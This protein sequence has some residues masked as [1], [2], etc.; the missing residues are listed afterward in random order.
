MRSRLYLYQL[1]LSILSAALLASCTLSMEEWAIPEEQRGQGEIYTEENEYGRI[2]Y[3]FADSVLYVT[4]NIQEQY[5]VRVEADSILYFSDQM[6]EEWRPYV[7]Q[8]MAAGISHLLPYGLNSRVISVVNYGGFI[9][10]V[11]T[12]VNLETVYKHLKYSFDGYASAPDIDPDQIDSIDLEDYG[13]QM[14]IDPETGDTTITDWND[15]DISKGIRPAYARRRSLRHTRADDIPEEKIGKDNIKSNTLIELSLDTRASD[16]GK[17]KE[18]NGYMSAIK[19]VFV[20][21]LVAEVTKASK[22]SKNG[23]VYAAFRIK[24]THFSK[25]HALKDTDAGVEEEWTDTWSEWDF[26]VETG[27]DYKREGGKMDPAVDDRLGVPM[28]G[29]SDMVKSISARNAASKPMNPVAMQKKRFSYVKVRIPISAVPVAFAIIVEG[30]ITPTFELNGCISVSSKYTSDVVRTGSRVVKGQAPEKF[31]DKVVKEGSFT[32]PSV[33]INGS[34]KVGLK[35]RIA[36]GFEVG[37]T[38]GVTIGANIEGY[39]EGNA[40]FKIAVK[41]GTSNMNGEPKQYVTW[42]DFSGTPFK[43]YVDVYG[44][45]TVFV[46]PLGIPVWEKQVVKFLTKRLIN[47]IPEST[48]GIRFKGGDSSFGAELGKEYEGSEYESIGTIYGWYVP[49]NSL[50]PF[51]ALMGSSKFYPAMKLYVGDIKDDKWMWMKRAHNEKIETFLPSSQWRLI[52]NHETYYFREYTYWQKLDNLAGKKAGYIYLVPTFV[53]FSSD[54]ILHTD[55]NFDD[56]LVKDAIDEVIEIKE[57]AVMIDVAKPLIETVSAKHLES[58]DMDGTISHGTYISKDKGG[59]QNASQGSQA[60]VRQYFFYAT[61]KVQGGSY[62]KGWG[63][64]VYV[65][66]PNKK[67]LMKKI[68]PVNKLRS[69]RYTFLFSFF[70]DWAPQ[71]MAN[72]EGDNTSKLYFCV[73]PY[74]E[75]ELEGEVMTYNATDRKSTK[76]YPIEYFLE[77]N[78]NYWD[79][80]KKNKGIFG[81]SDNIILTP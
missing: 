57:S 12:R 33:L 29:F 13:F 6:P 64:T 26:A 28:F 59:V 1:V 56:Q 46:A 35:G 31:E 74:W 14:Q 22:N 8:K 66:S 20:E 78:S 60:A 75:M 76:S 3:E 53:S 52:E 27:Y 10:A 40:S 25:F 19:K 16:I 23:E 34:Y 37:G 32:A 55:C 45:V 18:T 44:D 81:E 51:F 77:N 5:L 50:S 30:N 70:S 73:T 11:T 68:I 2:S 41:E 36:A 69:G 49:Y 15:Y 38:A 61:V 4:E 48:T 9:K 39:F 65:L 43:F 54:D 21:K 79:N 47:K 58:R 72:E 17:Y 42:H 62:M 71:S 24:S 67:W 63:L 80:I 7:G